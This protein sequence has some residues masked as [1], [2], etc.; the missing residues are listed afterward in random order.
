MLNRDCNYN[1]TIFYIFYT[2][3]NFINISHA[4]TRACAEISEQLLKHVKIV[5][6]LKVTM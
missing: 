3:Y 1:F 2:N 6:K 4:R 5:K